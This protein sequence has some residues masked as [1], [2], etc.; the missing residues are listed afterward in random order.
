[1]E[2]ISLFER[3]E[4]LKKFMIHND[5]KA[6]FTTIQKHY[7]N[8]L[9][10]K[11]TDKTIRN[12]LKIIKATSDGKNNPT[13]TLDIYT[14]IHKLYRDLHC[15]LK[16]I[17]IYSPIKVGAPL[18]SLNN[19]NFTTTSNLFN[20]SEL[21]YGFFK[22][23]DG[24]ISEY[25]TSLY[26]KLGKFFELYE[27][28]LCQYVLDID[29]RDNYINFMFVDKKNMYTFYE[30]ILSIQNYTNGTISIRSPYRDLT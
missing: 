1:M 2:K 9:C 10:E 11:L 6:K 19:I 28:S 12:D 16:H 27:E 17:T 14:E 13:Y 23:K 25:L 5:G 20:E 7:K 18:S 8:T 15:I 26:R 3:R 4:S 24:S 22:L 29:I 21:F 30:Y